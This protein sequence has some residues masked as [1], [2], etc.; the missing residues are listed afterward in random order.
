MVDET[1]LDELKVDETAVDEIAVDEIAVDE[2]G[3][4]LFFCILEPLRVPIS[5]GMYFASKFNGLKFN[6]NS[7][8][9]LN[10]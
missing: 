3:P 1:G 8:P 7:E 6:S 2:P 9:I 10:Q 4:H 5:Y